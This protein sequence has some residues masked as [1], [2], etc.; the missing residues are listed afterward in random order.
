[1]GDFA[2]ELH[3]TGTKPAQSF[4]GDRAERL[5]RE[6]VVRGIVMALVGIQGSSSGAE[7]VCI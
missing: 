3:Y 6:V 7:G 2:E 4:K 5:S 1:V